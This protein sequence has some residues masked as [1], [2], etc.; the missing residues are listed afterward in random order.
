MRGSGRAAGGR[1]GCW[2]GGQRGM[3][4]AHGTERAMG[5]RQGCRGMEGCV[6]LGG[7]QWKG[8]GHVGCGRERRA[9]REGRERG[10]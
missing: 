7:S 3:G 9:S 1:Y 4:R 5:V 10:G 6:G 2:G 8:R